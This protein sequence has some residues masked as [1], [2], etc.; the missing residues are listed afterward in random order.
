MFVT[1]FFYPVVPLF[2]CTCWS[3]VVHTLYRVFLCI[4]L[5]PVLGMPILYGLL[6]H[7]IVG[8]VCSCYLSLCSI[9]LLHNIL[10]VTL[11]LVLLLFHSQ[12][13]LLSLP[14]KA[15]GTCL[16]HWQAVCLFIFLMYWPCITLL[17]HLFFKTCTSLAS[18]SCIPSCFASLFHWFT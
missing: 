11:G 18:V 9:S 3:V 6:S 12:L 10:F 1:V 5:L 13:M 2:P 4:V 17:F 7:R 15:R 16:L 14:S 8:I